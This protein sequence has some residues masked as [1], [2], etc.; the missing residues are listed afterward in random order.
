MKHK[1]LNAAIFI[2]ALVLSASVLPAQN[3][4][5]IS[6]DFSAFN[7]IDIDYDFDVRVV[8]SRNYSISVNVD[9]VLK[10]YVQ[11]YV[12]NRTLYISLDQKSL[13][14][15]VKKLY[16]GRR[17]PTPVLEATVYMPDPLTSIKMAGG[18]KLSVDDNIE[19]KEMFI[20]MKENARI[21]KLTVDA[22][23]AELVTNGKCFA[24]L[25]I[26]AD[27]IKLNISGGSLIEL[28]QDSEKLAIVTGGSAEVHTGGETLNAEL[29][30]SGSSRVTMEGKTD[31]L[32]VTGSGSSFVDAVNLKTSDC[33]VKLSNSSKVYEAATEAVHIDLSGNSTLAFDGDPKIDII[34]VKSSTIQ[35]YSN[36]KK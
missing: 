22:G 21:E 1:V 9:D 23:S 18:S 28:E 25:T 8:Q 2:I 24:D 19:C 36:V 14:S 20:E 7:S 12:K 3:V 11:T 13:P 35:R 5:H 17:A 26:Y 4:K 34:N 10:D 32:S 27:E 30:T 6:H 31:K 15:D 33:T 29:T 16:K